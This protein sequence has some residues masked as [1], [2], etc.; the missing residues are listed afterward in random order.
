MLARR[1]NA[2]V[3]YLCGQQYGT[4]S[5]GIHI[6]QCQDKWLKV[7]AHKPKRERRP[8]PRAPAGLDEALKSG[9]GSYNIDELN[10]ANFQ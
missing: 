1:P 10:A 9:N 4:A 8:L 6:P 7:E 2:V 3:C 5:I